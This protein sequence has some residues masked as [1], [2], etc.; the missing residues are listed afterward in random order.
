MFV[1]Y[2]ITTNRKKF[3]NVYLKTESRLNVELME[4]TE[5]EVKNTPDFYVQWKSVCDVPGNIRRLPSR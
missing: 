3:E 4:V 5:T 1:H 2:D